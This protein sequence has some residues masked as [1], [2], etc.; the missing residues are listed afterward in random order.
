M[1]TILIV[2][3]YV[4]KREFL[5]TLPGYGDHQLPEV[6]D[7]IERLKMVRAAHPDLMITDILMQ[8]M[9]GCEFVN[10]LCEV[11]SANGAGRIS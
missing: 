10:P 2:D 5:I 3:D 4:L 7:G 1:A 11:V 8:H 9:D 6:A